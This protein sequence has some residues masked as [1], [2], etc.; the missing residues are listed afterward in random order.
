MTID[1]GKAEY[2]HGKDNEEFY[3]THTFYSFD[4]SC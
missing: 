3:A 4:A 2:S 1:N